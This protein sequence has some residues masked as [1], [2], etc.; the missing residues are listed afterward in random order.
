MEK[1]QE[2]ISRPAWVGITQPLSRCR[3]LHRPCL[4]SLPGKPGMDLQLARASVRG[5]QPRLGG[6]TAASF[7][8]VSSLPRRGSEVDNSRANS[9]WV[10]SSP[11]LTHFAAFSEGI[12]LLLGG[13]CLLTGRRT[14]MH[15]TAL[16]SAGRAGV[17]WMRVGQEATRLT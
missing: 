9:C 11:W 6:G 8:P 12:C 4:P 14:G 15:L 5:C 2:G 1:P 7:V 16:R 10:L 3:A 13:C 17:L